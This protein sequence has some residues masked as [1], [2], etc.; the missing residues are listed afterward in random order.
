M[1]VYRFDGAGCAGFP[2]DPLVGIPEGM[3]FLLDDAGV[4]VRVVNRW[5][6]SLPTSGAPAP[7]TWVA[8]AGDV[9]AWVGFLEKRGVDVLDDR[10]V[11]REAV[12]AYHGERRMGPLAGRLDN[13]SWARAISSIS[14]F[15]EWAESEGLIDGTPFSYR[16]Q[17]IRG[18]DG[19]SRVVRRNL[20]AARR[21]KRHVSVRW[22]EQ[23]FWTCSWRWVWLACCPTAGTTRPFGVGSRPATPPPG[24]WPRRPGCGPRSSPRCWCGRCPH[25]HLTSRRWSLWLFRG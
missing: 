23:D 2:A 19:A 9:K 7:K 6:R 11:L 5:L 8:Y 17:A 1:R 24:S 3:P 12:A 21:A 25:R 13:S 22:L 4:P 16:L 20:A 18:S 10:S 14:S 15:Y